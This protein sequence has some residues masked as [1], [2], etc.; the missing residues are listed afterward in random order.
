MAVVLQRLLAVEAFQ[1][2]SR[3]GEE[4]G[5]MLGALDRPANTHAP[6]SNAL[7]LCNLSSLAPCW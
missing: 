4:D 7:P 6:G 3:G 5:R 1:V 2:V